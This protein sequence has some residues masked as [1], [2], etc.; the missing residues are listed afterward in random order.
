MQ[1]FL[2]TAV[3]RQ[4]ANDTA[5]DCPLSNASGDLNTLAQNLPFAS[6]DKFLQSAKMRGTKG[7]RDDEVG[8]NLAHGFRARPPE[9]FHGAFIPFSDVAVG[10]HHDHLAS[11]AVS[12]TSRSCRRLPLAAWGH[13]RSCPTME[14]YP[15]I[16]RDA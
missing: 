4:A 7:G 5:A 16:M 10:C 15:N 3:I 8:H 9:H 11:R 14:I 6:V 1:F 13:G 2:A 12:S